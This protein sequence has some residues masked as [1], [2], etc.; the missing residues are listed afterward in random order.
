M[1]IAREINIILAHGPELSAAGLDYYQLGLWAG[2]AP[3]CRILA[4]NPLLTSTILKERLAAFLHHEETRPVVLA[5]LAPFRRA[6]QIKKILLQDFLLDPELIAEV[7]LQEALD[8]PDPRACLLKAQNLILRAAAQLSRAQPLDRRELPVITR[9]LVWGDSFPALKAACNLADLNYP[10][11]LATPKDILQPLVPGAPLSQSPPRELMDLLHRVSTHPLITLVT[12]A[13]ILSFQGTS[14]DFCLRLQTP[15]GVREE[16]VGAA[17]LAPEL[18]VVAHSP[19]AGQIGTCPACLTLTQWEELW[20]DPHQTSPQLCPNGPEKI[21]A[22]LTGFSEAAHPLMLQ[23]VLAGIAGLS[24]QE[25][26]QVYLFLKDAK[27]AAPSLEAELERAQEA[28]LIV[29]KLHEPPTVSVA[30]NRPVLTFFEPVLRRL[31]TLRCHVLVLEEV[32]RPAA[33]NALLAELMGLLEGPQGFLQPD[34][35]RNLAV[36]TNRRAIL[37]VGPGRGVMDLDQAFAQVDAAV[38]EIHRF[39]GHG[40]A[41]VKPGWAIVD[42]GRCT[43]CLTCYRLCPH[44]AIT[45]D[46][47]AIVHPLA[48]Q[49]CGVCASECPQDAIEIHNFTKDQLS[50]VL[51]TVDFRLAPRI[52]AFM[53][54]NSAWE[55]YHA[56]LKLSDVTLPLGFMAV[57]MPCAGKI[58]AAYLLRAFVQGARGVLVL[59]CHP[60][61][62]KSH[63]GPDLATARVQLVQDRLREIGLN[64][65]RLRLKTLAANTPRDFLAAVEQMQNIIH[66][67]PTL[68]REDNSAPLEVTKLPHTKM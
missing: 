59:T 13:D 23:R 64:P 2:G 54:Q 63:R 35:V 44:G 33:H 3:R 38:T 30:E 58:D 12:A 24:A 40:T 7:D 65:Q 48:C 20:A 60:D 41:I 53:C 5:A 61:N 10:V 50:A 16:R 28:G 51:S 37:V 56:A 31:V 45:W 6:R 43:L 67:M 55:A 9:V 62:C 57:K 39:L 1:T 22:F 32:Y 42:R 29:I 19:S 21:I 4:L 26:C 52:V 36:A 66:R 47:R 17:I 27:V 68:L 18:E 46:N 14:G 8:S 49:G 15:Q 11:L 34:N 25:N